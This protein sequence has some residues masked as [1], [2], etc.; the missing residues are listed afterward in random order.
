MRRA[1][2]R[3][4]AGFTL[5]E[6]LVSVTL[7][8]L[9]GIALTDGLHLARR[10]LQSAAREDR[11]SW[12]IV[13]AQRFLRH[14]LES[15]E[16]AGSAPVGSAHALQG[17]SSRLTF[18]ATGPLAVNEGIPSVFAIGLAVRQHNIDQQDLVVRWQSQTADTDLADNTSNPGEVLV[19]GV[20]SV[21][22]QYLPAALTSGGTTE[23]SDWLD[24]WQGRSDLPALIR[25]EVT[26]KPGS[27]RVWPP[28]VVQL[29]LTHDA[30]CVFDVVAQ[31]CRK[32]G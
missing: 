23:V 20:Q 24:E 17:D 11:D 16:P 15:A 5:I 26:F 12:E 30:G 14:A 13:A 8:A 25:L 29:H 10:S 32:E 27:R 21:R 7:M 4:A 1:R 31:D 22:W 6:M 19:T 28:L 9:I 2:G 18:R 3:P